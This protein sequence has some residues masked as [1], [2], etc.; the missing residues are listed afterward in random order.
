MPDIQTAFKTAL[1]RTLQQWDDDDGEQVPQPSS[2]INTTINN[3]VPQP[4]QNIQG[5]PMTNTTN[6]PHRF[7][8]KNNISRTTFN[9]IKDNPGSTRKE[10]IIALEHLGFN[11]G[12][13][14]SLISQMRKNKLIHMTND[15]Y[16]ADADEYKP[17]KNYK[18]VQK[19]VK[20][21]PVEVKPK[22]KYVKKSDA[23]GGIGALLKAKIES[24]P[25]P[26]ATAPIERKPFLT[27]LVRTQSP[28][29]IIENMNVLQA[30]ELYDYLRKIFGG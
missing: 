19:A 3:S 13:T 6:Q 2:T 26:V 27:K 1:S 14:S 18:P 20:P 17:L 15:L 12:S 28:E 25:M 22:R 23:E 10:I 24:A 9:Y 11:E 30:R 8:V 29:S 16:Y 4:S 21:A 7:P 5:I